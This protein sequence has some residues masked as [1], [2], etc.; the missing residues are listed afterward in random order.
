MEVTDLPNSMRIMHFN[1]K[2]ASGETIS[3]EGNYYVITTPATPAVRRVKY[4]M[5]SIR[6]MEAF[7]YAVFKLLRAK[8]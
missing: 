4:S 8:K 6:D 1:A 3:E 5:D 2:P 7:Y